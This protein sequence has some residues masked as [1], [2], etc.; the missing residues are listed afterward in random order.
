MRLDIIQCCTCFQE[1]CLDAIKNAIHDKKTSHRL[2]HCIIAPSFGIQTF[3]ILQKLALVNI[4]RNKKKYPRNHQSERIRYAIKAKPHIMSMRVVTF[5]LKANPTI[6]HAKKRKEKSL[7]EL[8][9]FHAENS[10][11][12]PLILIARS[13][14]SSFM[15]FA[16]WNMFIGIA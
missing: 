12:R 13:A 15:S 5:I 16:C 2:I 14:G 9:H 4:A 8:V 3:S 7:F 1:D 10:T 11:R 6:S